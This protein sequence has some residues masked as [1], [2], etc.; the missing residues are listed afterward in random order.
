MK[1][2]FIAN[3]IED[4]IDGSRA[5]PRDRT[6]TEAKMWVRDNAKAMFLTS[7]ALEYVQL[8]PLL[9][10]ETA[11][12]M[13]DNLCRIHEQKSATNKL[14]L[15]QKFHEYRMASSDSVVQHIAKI[16][17]MA[18]QIEDVGERVSELT[19]IAKILG[20]LSP[21]YSTLQTAWDSV[22]PTRQTLN[23]L[24][25]RLIREELRLGVESE[26]GASAFAV[27][28]R[29]GQTKGK[30]RKSKKD[31]KCYRCHKTGHFA[32]EC[33]NKQGGKDDDD[34]SRDCAFIA[35]KAT[36]DSQLRELLAAKQCEVWLTDS[37]ASRHMTYR[38][39]WISNY[40]PNKDGGKV[41]LGDGEEC[42]IAGEGVVY[43]KKYTNGLWCDARI[44]NVLYI[45]N[46]KKNLFS[47]GACTKKG[48]EVNFTRECVNVTRERKVVAS[49][50]RQ[51]NDIYRMCFR[52]S[53][54]RAEEA[55]VSEHNLRVWHE[56]LGHVDKRAIRELVK[57]GLVH[58]V[59]MT[60]TNDFV[61]EMCRLGKAHR[62]PFKAREKVSTK[63]GEIIHTDVCGPMSVETPG[64]AKYFLTF[65]DDAT[66]YRHVYF[67][68]HK[69]EVAEK[70]R[71]FE[72]SIANKFGRTMKIL[73]SDN[74]R[75]FC[76]KEMDNYLSQKGIK[77]ENTAPYTPQQNGKAERD[78]RTIVESARTMIHAKSL[79]LS[80]WAEAVNTAIYVSNR[81]VSSGG[82]ATPYEMWVGKKP[83][84]SHLRIFGSVAYVHTPKQFTKKLD[85]RGKKMILVGY[86]GDSTNYR[87]YDPS[88]KSVIITRDAT[89]FERVGK[90]NLVEE[91]PHDETIVLHSPQNEERNEVTGREAEDVDQDVRN[92]QEL[93]QAAPEDGRIL[94]NRATIHRPARYDADVAEYTTPNSYE[95]ATQGTQAEQWAQAINEELLAHQNNNTWSIVP[96]T[97]GVKTIDSKWVFKIKD[98]PNK[99]K[100]R[101]KARLCAR[102]FLQQQGRDYTETFA[103][104]VR[105]DSLRVLLAAVSRPDIAFAVNSVSK[106]LN[107]HS[108][109]HWHA[110]K[111]IFA[112]L[113]GTISYGIE[114]KSGGSEAEL[115]G[116]SDADYASDIET[117]RSTTGYIFYIA[118]G[119]VSWSSQRQKM[120]VLSTT[121][122]EYVA[123]ATATKEA[124]WLRKLLNDISHSC[125]KETTIYVDNQSAI[126]LVKNPE[127]HKRTK[128][129]DIRYHYIR[130]K[131]ENKDIVVKYI[132]TE[133]QR[134]DILTKTLP[135]DR[136]RKLCEIINVA[137]I[138]QV[139]AQ[140]AVVLK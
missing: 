84:L 75:E 57:K 137:S 62:M 98:E 43:V 15:L 111:R 109:E 93:E 51:D 41:S 25:E 58:G 21:K 86:E 50:V 20:S 28:K 48:F 47:V 125:E 94:R 89:F 95:E 126:R 42:D 76:N 67:L 124:M 36:N 74:G 12:D 69:A 4:I 122:A 78:N 116:F 85:L 5:M 118:N 2:L 13:W 39:D 14:L 130:E 9:V 17:N 29:E 73:R 91:E 8:E 136:F 138:Q 59:T 53:Q 87:V 37:G 113:K 40:R 44:E 110:V 49:G 61:C 55:N 80:L 115:I 106:F 101:F 3:E 22:D 105:Y 1:T 35:E 135:R 128:H 65:K 11:K 103:P 114:Y 68:R 99:K 30:P 26:S 119:P 107:N 64:G 81:T 117:R 6:T 34:Q 140:T 108:V 131:Y 104:V 10:C 96:R 16:R 97:P 31:I 90:I 127:F 88:T 134:A 52:V 82:D 70:F 60:N 102:G 120:V 92:A 24:E 56:R 123:A 33:S 100:R 18:A 77:K 79:P 121:E 71:V 32:R 19:V 139:D 38:R 63:P 72:K 23:N 132:P 27:S 129:I 45:P 83:M 54:F 66:G 112:Y 7:S 46:L 133:L